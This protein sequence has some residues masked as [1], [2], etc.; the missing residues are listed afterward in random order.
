MIG[1]PLSQSRLQALYGILDFLS[2]LKESDDDAKIWGRIAEKL[3]VAVDAQSASYY[4]YLQARR[5]LLPRYCLGVAAQNLRAVAVDLRTGACGW[6]ALHREPL[7]IADAE[8]DSR[9]D[10]KADAIAEIKVKTVLAVPITDRLDLLG[11]LE[12]ANK[13]GGPFSQDDQRLAQAACR[14]AAIALR[15]LG[16]EARADRIAARNASIIENL[17]GGFLAVDTRGNLMLCNPAARRILSLS[18]EM[19][20][21]TPI[22]E[23]LA[24]VPKITEILLE[25][26]AM[27][28]T[29]A[30]QE[31][32]AVIGGRDRVLGY[33]T[34]IIQDPQGEMTGAGITFQDITSTRS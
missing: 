33:S 15:A 32:T 4:S 2:Q 9:F 31:L 21:H 34:I 1:D 13:R 19:P 5:E 16:L 23:G 10:E 25:T 17:G 28:R 3:C 27:R 24:H 30:R 7:I 6:A 22:Q 8:K 18:P 14:A 11:V 29:I 12:F 26:L 20:L